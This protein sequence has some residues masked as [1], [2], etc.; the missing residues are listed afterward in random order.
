MTV[1]GIK[2]PTLEVE[3]RNVVKVGL[4]S[5]V[6]VEVVVGLEAVE[7]TA[8]E[9]KEPGEVEQEREQLLKP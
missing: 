9:I 6:E 3:V 7:E 1:S 4:E 2:D 5:E 8:V